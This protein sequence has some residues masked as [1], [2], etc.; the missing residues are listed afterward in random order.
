MRGR[1][2]LDGGGARETGGNPVIQGEES[3]FLADPCTPAPVG[4][5]MGNVRPLSQYKFSP[6]EGRIPLHTFTKPNLI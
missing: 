2:P 6:W 4:A 3:E 5:A 1:G